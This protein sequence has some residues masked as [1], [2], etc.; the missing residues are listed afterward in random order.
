MHSGAT[1]VF[2]LRGTHPCSLVYWSIEMDTSPA[3]ASDAMDV[4]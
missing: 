2:R 3:R 1:D 4:P